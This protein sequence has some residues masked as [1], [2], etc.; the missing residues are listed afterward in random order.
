MRKYLNFLII[1]SA[2]FFLISCAPIIESVKVVLGTSTKALED[3]RI[4][5]IAKTYKCGIDDCYDAVVA[6]ARV[7]GLGRVIN[8]EGYFNIFQQD[9][10]DGIIVVM[11]VEGSVDTTEVGIFFTILDN[12]DIHIEVTSLSSSAKR[13]VAQYIFTELNTRFNEV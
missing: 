1:I 10:I 7:D 8:K 11:G 2:S 9:P 3:A 13:K 4:T 5:A 6:M 12:R